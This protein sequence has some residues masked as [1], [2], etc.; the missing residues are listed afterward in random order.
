MKISAT[1]CL[2]QH[3][4][5]VLTGDSSRIHNPHTA[6]VPPDTLPRRIHI[7]SIKLKKI[8]LKE[9]PEDTSLL[10]NLIKNKAI[11]NYI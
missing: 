2:L 5:P 8:S 7:Y 11:E 10:N 9:N 3:R 6:P 1:K 4:R